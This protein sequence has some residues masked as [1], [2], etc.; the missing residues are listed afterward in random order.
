LAELIIKALKKDDLEAVR[1][2]VKSL[3]KEFPIPES[4]V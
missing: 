4:F 1:K 3:A 2:E